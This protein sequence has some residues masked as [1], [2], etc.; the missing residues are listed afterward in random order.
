MLAVAGRDLVREE[1][2]RS[3]GRLRQHDGTRW[4]TTNVG[5]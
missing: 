4:I 2:I 1:E 5:G 3:Y